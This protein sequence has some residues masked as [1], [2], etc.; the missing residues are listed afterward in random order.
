MNRSMWHLFT[1]SKCRDT[2]ALWNTC[3]AA[4]DSL[5]NSIN[6]M[7]VLQKI[8]FPDNFGMQSRYDL[9]PEKQDRNF[10]RAL[11]WVKSEPEP[12]LTK[13]D[14]IYA[15]KIAVELYEEAVNLHKKAILK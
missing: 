6:A 15:E 10:D 5:H 14:G 2:S 8:R 13:E 11:S 7:L 12:V 1:V 4:L 3:L 9:L